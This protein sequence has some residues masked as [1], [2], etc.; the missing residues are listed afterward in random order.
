M[1]TY[2]EGKEPRRGRH[3]RRSL[4]RILGL[5]FAAPFVVPKLI[6]LALAQ[7]HEEVRWSFPGGIYFDS[8]RSLLQTIDNR[9]RLKEAFPIE[10]L[11]YLFPLNPTEATVRKRLIKRG[12]IVFQD[13]KAT[14]IAAADSFDFHDDFV[15]NLTMH[16]PAAV[17]AEAEQ[18]RDRLKLNFQSESEAIA[19]DLHDIPNEFGLPKQ[20]LIVGVEITN[21][22]AIYSLRS[23]IGFRRLIIDVDLTK[24]T[25]VPAIGR[26]P[27]EM[28]AFLGTGSENLPILQSVLLLAQDCRVSVGCNGLSYCPEDGSI[29]TDPYYIARY[30]TTG[31]SHFF[32]CSII[33]RSQL[34]G[35]E[36]STYG[37]YYDR[38]KAEDY[39]KKECKSLLCC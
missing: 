10:T 6:R 36:E 9:V 13:A 15:G 12:D 3:V 7:A 2:E 38:Q 14:N 26:R 11:F 34:T 25:R 39:L 31:G 5:T 4:V 35:K 27:K 23:K 29:A 18:S 22:Q 17:V 37:P 30:R 20:F 28:V 16:F 8:F 19:L 32:S 1:A 24:A 21:A 33:L